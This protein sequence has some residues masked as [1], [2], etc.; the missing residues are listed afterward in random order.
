MIVRVSS[1]TSQ[2]Y[3]KSGFTVQRCLDLKRGQF[4]QKTDSSV[5]ESDTSAASGQNNG[6]P[7]QKRNVKKRRLKYG[8]IK[9]WI[10]IFK[11]K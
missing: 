11:R 9:E 7:D 5:V 4:D 10:L 1:I 6:Q 3:H 8:K 2:I